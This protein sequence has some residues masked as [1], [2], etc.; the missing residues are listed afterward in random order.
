ME[1]ATLKGGGRFGNPEARPLRTFE[2]N[3]KMAASE[4]EHSIS[5]ILGKIGDCEQP[6]N[7]IKGSCY[8]NVQG[9]TVF[10]LIFSFMLKSNERNLYIFHLPES[11][12][13]LGGFYEILLLHDT[14]CICISSTSHK[15]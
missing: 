14:T 10:K 9:L 7:V 1:R 12:C 15:R 13:K 3:Y 5:T 11:K 4:S 8:Q 6:I 2:S